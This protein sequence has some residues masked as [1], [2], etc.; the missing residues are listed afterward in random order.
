MA[1][2]REKL[3][4]WYLAPVGIVAVALTAGAEFINLSGRSTDWV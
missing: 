1:A 4:L 2:K 3:S